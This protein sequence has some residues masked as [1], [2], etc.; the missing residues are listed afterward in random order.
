MRRRFN[1]GRLGE[2]GFE[3]DF[4]N[5][6]EGVANLVDV[7]LVI[8][9]GLM[10]ALVVNWNVDIA[11]KPGESAVRGE[12][13]TAPG[14]LSGEGERLDDDTRYEELNV[15]VYRDPVTGKLYMVEKGE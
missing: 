12:E 14:G 9:V 6:L 4:A 1:G 5:P 11:A 15:A 7:M 2:N 10:L 13:I 8:A 3:S